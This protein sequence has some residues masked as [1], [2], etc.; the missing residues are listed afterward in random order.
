MKDLQ[1]LFVTLQKEGIKFMNIF[2]NAF[3]TKNNKA[4]F[5]NTIVPL[6]L[7]MEGG[8]KKVDFGK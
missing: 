5:C 6:S 1:V 2:R 3:C 4:A 8:T 7:Q